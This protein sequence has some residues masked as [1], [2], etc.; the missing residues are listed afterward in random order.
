[1]LILNKILNTIFIGLIYIYRYTLSP[2]LGPKCRFYPSCS[3]YGLES[4]KKHGFIKAFW[5]TSVRL[6]KCHPFN[7]GGVDLP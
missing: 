5:K 1:M 6:S 4:F 3:E 7:P 2:L